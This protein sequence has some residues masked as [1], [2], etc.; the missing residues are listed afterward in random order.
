MHSLCLENEYIKTQEQ[1]D[2]YIQLIKESPILAIDTEF[3]RRRT[4]Y[5]ELAL[6]QVFDGKHLALIDPCCELDLTQFWNILKDTSILKVL[7]S[8][9]ED[10]EV[11]M[12]HGDCIPAPLFDT[13]FAMTLLGFGNSVGFAMMVNK[14]LCQEIDKSE[15]RTNWLQR[16]L[17]Q[18]QLDYAAGDVIFL[19]P[20][21]EIVKKLIDEK[22]WLDIVLSESALM[23]K[24]RQYQ[25]PDENLY[26]EIKNA[27]QL[28]SSDLGVLKKLAIWRREKAKMKNL[29]L[30]FILK[31]HNMIEIAKYKPNSLTALRK[32]PGIEAMEVNKSGKEILACI[33]DAG[34]LLPEQNPEKIIRLVDFPSYKNEVKLLKQKIDGIAKLNDIPIEALSSKKQ[35]NQLISW[36]WKYEKDQKKN[37][38]IPDLLSCWR[39]KLLKGK[40]KEWE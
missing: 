31:E 32:L 3:M 14:L 35:I 11:F 29:A 4:L 20:C 19:L 34:S 27:W 30:G 5:P 6:I 13:Q 8:P 21:F 10:L 40:I 38:L 36:S 16:P 15:S 23:A 33:S 25:I 12:K 1:L 39:Y 7:H 28:N 37:K 17:T 26:L 9:S 2:A 18:K 22:E 24:K